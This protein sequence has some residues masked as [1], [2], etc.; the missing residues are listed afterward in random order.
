MLVF[1]KVRPMS[2]NSPMSEALQHF[3]V[4]SEHHDAVGK[5]RAGAVRAAKKSMAASSGTGEAADEGAPPDHSHAIAAAVR[6]MSKRRYRKK[7]PKAA[8]AGAAAALAL[9]LVAVGTGVPISP[10]L[11]AEVHQS[12]EMVYRVQRAMAAHCMWPACLRGT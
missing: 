10:T 7:V 4:A 12:I 5:A 11:A 9:D 3:D 2:Q 1:E 8:R 6:Q